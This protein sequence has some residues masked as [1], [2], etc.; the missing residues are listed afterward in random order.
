MDHPTL[1]SSSSTHSHLFTRLFHF[2][3]CVAA[4]EWLTH[5]PM[6]VM[7]SNAVSTSQTRASFCLWC[8]RLHSLPRS[9]TSAPAPI[10][11]PETLS[12]ICN[13]IRL[14]SE[15]LLSSW[16]PSLLRDFFLTSIHSGSL[17]MS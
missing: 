1:T 10:P 2:S 7:L 17:R 8:H 3:S 15:R 9:L 16:A 12:C 13:S 6:R 5:T 4:S 11:F 14:T